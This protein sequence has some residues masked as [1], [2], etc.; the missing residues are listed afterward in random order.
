[1][2]IK[3][4]SPLDM[5]LHL[6]DGKMLENVINFSSEYFSGFLVMPNLLPPLTNKNQILAYKEKI[7][8]AS[9]NKNFQSYMSV[10]MS[11][12]L[13]A[14]MIQELKDT[15]LVAK[16][17]PSGVTTNS[18][19]GLA[20]IDIDSMRETLEAMSEFNIALSIHG[21]TNGFCLDREREFMPIFEEL[22]KNFPK[23]KIIME[24]I[25]TK[26]AVKTLSKFDN[27]YATV[28]VHHLLLTLDDV[29][30]SSLN[31]HT[32]CKPI[33]KT[34]QDKE[35][36]Q[37]A[38]ILGN[39]KIMFGSDSAPHTKKSK[40]LNGAAGV[41]SAPIILQVLADFFY[42]HNKLELLQSFIS[43]NAKQIYCINPPQKEV[44]LEK[45]EF[46]VP[47]GFNGL[48]PLFADKKLEFSLV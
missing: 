33:L 41:F 25:S 30:G 17:Y 27:L 36:I 39:K 2:K 7:H 6:R 8:K 4:N 20:K 10:F 13:D 16:L 34:P 44:F 47:N 40:E 37:E 14:K 23:L 9:K 46:I 48:I 38:V 26:E 28:T 5:H 29:I 1:M 35:A 15:I 19:N 21:E 31:P 12:S 32:F 42:K 3:L 43:D 18:K 22:A 11:E 45:K 24:H